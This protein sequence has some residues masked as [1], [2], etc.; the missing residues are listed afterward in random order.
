MSWKNLCLGSVLGLSVLLPWPGNTALAED[1]GVANFGAAANG[2]PWAIALE[3]GFFKEAGVDISG[4][5]SSL[6][7]GPDLRVLLGGNL[8]YAEAG[9]SAVAGANQAGADLVVVSTNANTVADILW[10]VPKNSPIN[11]IKDLKGKKLAFSNPGSTTQALDYLLVDYAGFKRDDVQFIAAGSLGAALTALENGGVDVS[12]IAEPAYALNG[13]KYKTIARGS[14]VFPPFSNTIG[15][16]SRKTLQERPQVVRGILIA[17]RK[18]VE[19]MKANR[20]ESAAIIAKYYKMDPAVIEAVMVN[21]MDHGTV[22]GVPYWGPG[23]IEYESLN[24]L[25]R[26]MNLIGVISGDLDW[27][28][29]VDESYLPADLQSKKKQ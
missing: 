15:V 4:V 23:N 19:Y 13:S 14:E 12:P 22:K 29:Y 24:N 2:M 21:L 27:N 17:R 7:G 9:L 26:A 25:V 1:I 11:S 5:I 18:A 6:G 28:K 8:P 20:K 16:A 3:K 10:V